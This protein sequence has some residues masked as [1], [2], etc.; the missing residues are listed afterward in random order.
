MSI[1]TESSEYCCDH[2]SLTAITLN[3]VSD[4]DIDYLCCCRNQVNVQKIPAITFG[5]R[6]VRQEP[7]SFYCF[8]LPSSLP[9]FVMSFEG[10]TA[11]TRHIKVCAVKRR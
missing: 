2:A 11:V 7:V 1:I 6:K 3:L 4:S 9:L 5:Q 8:A 10:D